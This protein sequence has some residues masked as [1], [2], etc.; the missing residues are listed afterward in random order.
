MRGDERAL[1]IVGEHL[2]INPW[3]KGVL[4]AEAWDRQTGLEVGGVAHVVVALLDGRRVQGKLP[5]FSPQMPDVVIEPD[6]DQRERLKSP[7]LRAEEIA[8]L[9][10]LRGN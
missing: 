4:Q 8:Y 9:G 2:R 1:L 3:D 7:R 5:K 6:P 10:F